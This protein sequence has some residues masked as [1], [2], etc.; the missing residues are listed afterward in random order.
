ME[1]FPP[2]KKKMRH[3]PTSTRPKGLSDVNLLKFLDR[4]DCHNLIGVAN[5]DI[6]PLALVPRRRAFGLDVGS[7]APCQHIRS[8]E[9]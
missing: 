1:E 4:V 9:F 6:C 5:L 2:F 3:T 7:T 8:R